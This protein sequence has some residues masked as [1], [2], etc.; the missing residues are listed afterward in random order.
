MTRRTT[1]PNNNQS[2]ADILRNIVDA[3]LASAPANNQSQS[4]PTWPQPEQMRGSIVPEALKNIGSS[5][6]EGLW[7]SNAL[8]QMG[9]QYPTISERLWGPAIAR[10]SAINEP[11]WGPAIA[12]SSAI[13]QVGNQPSNMAPSIMNNSALDMAE[14]DGRQR[15]QTPPWGLDAYNSLLARYSR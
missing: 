13:N 9:N 1:M 6:A 5:A 4:M 15:R 14:Q 7:W 12:R 11:L 2:F 3:G 8:D 10:S